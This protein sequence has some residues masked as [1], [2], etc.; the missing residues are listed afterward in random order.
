MDGATNWMS[1]AF[2]P[3]KG[4]FFLM[5]LEKCSIFSKS[6]EVWKAGESYYGGGARDVPGETPHQYLRA[7]DLATG[8]IAWEILQSSGEESWGGVLATASGLLFYCDNSGAF[9]AVDAATGAP[10]W[11]MQFN[12]EWKASPM[13][14]TA[15]GSQFVAVA[16]GANI[17]S[18]GLP[19]V[20]K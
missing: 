7:L 3:A 1:T 15:K 19:N 14:Y 6:S 18:F 10:L 5:A 8:K 13:T 12:T 4:L 2:D 16:A 11:H 17:V 9:A 20:N